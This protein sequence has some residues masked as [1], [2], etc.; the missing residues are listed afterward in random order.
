[1]VAVALLDGE[2]AAD[3][4]L[5]AALR[6]IVNEAYARGEVGL[7]REGT[8]RIADQ[9]LRALVAAGQLA[10]AREDGRVVGCVRVTSLGPRTAE[11]GLL[12]VAGERAG[13]GVGRA[14]M[15]FA[16]GLARERGHAAMRLTL[17][18]PREGSHPFKVR[19]AEWY[20]R[21]GYRVVGRADFAAMHPE[22]A[23]LLAV[24][25]DLVTFERALT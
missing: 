6:E 10:A 11:L 20:R 5:L 18:V 7:W 22:P 1:M 13:A 15:A 19:L 21:Q 17:L 25:C 23:A 3:G 2:A 14:L 8:E 24:A 16:H 12:A 4:G 9:D